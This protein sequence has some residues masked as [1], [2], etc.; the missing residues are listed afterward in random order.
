[1]LTNPPT[2]QFGKKNTKQGSSFLVRFSLGWE[3][4]RERERERVGAGR[5]YDDLTRI[6]PHK[7]IF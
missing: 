5:G 6:F 2:A 4:G 7:N 1:M 3:K